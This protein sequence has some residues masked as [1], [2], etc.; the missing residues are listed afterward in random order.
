MISS[1]DQ[2][3]RPSALFA[4]A[5]PER[6]LRIPTAALLIALPVLFTLFYTLLQVTFD[7]PG[8]LRQPAPEVLR[9]FHA[10]GPTLVAMWYGFALTPLLFLRPPS[11]WSAPSTAP[12]RRIS[13]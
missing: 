1:H 12:A 7:Y 6:D 5:M 3:N 10:G 4:G 13:S 11:C 8:I 2:P 9:Q